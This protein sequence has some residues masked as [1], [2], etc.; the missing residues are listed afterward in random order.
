MNIIHGP[1]C[2][3][4]RTGK[5]VSLILDSVER[6]DV[7]EELQNEQP[8]EEEYVQGSQSFRLVTASIE[9]GYLSVSDYDHLFTYMD[10]VIEY[11]VSHIDPSCVCKCLGLES[12]TSEEDLL[13]A[14]RDKFHGD[15]DG[16]VTWLKD[17]NIAFETS[18][19]NAMEEWEDQ[20][21]QV[22]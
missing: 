10:N 6:T 14:I 12:G 16:I 4:L 3:P 8:L 17:N 21:S 5:A 22:K 1:Q 19:Y 2:D 11:T 13:I 20:Q 15:Y 7:N 18:Y 9:D